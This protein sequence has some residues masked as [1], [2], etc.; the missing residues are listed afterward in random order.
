MTPGAAAVFLAAALQTGGGPSI[1]VGEDRAVSFAGTV[2]PAPVVEA[3]LSVDPSDGKHLL[4]GVIV[5]SKPDMTAIDCAALV[6]FD[7]GAAW[8]RRDLGLT[9]C[10]DPWTAFLPDGTAI[11][12]VLAREGAL[13]YRSADGGRTWNESVHFAGSHDHETLA[14]DA[15]SGPRR[16]SLVLLLRRVHEGDRD[17]PAAKRGLRRALRR[18]RTHV[19]S[20]GAGDPEQP[21]HQ[22][23]D[24]RRSLGR[25]AR[26]VVHGLSAAGPLGLG[27]AGRRTLL[28]PE[29]SRRGQD[30]LGADL[31]VPVLRP[32]LPD[33]RFS[34]TRTCTGWPGAAARARRPGPSPG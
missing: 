15:T 4:A 21:R 29:I 3:H 12:A 20:A 2:S 34:G 30:V 26:R 25:I 19:R 23:D 18:R 8:Q 31:D 9:D 6:S 27:V 28:A 32:E 7:G 33:A 14:V 22:H 13:V 17:R 5:V 11:L 24:G 10:A 1:R 16:G